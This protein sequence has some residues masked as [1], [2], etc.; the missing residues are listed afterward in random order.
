MNSCAKHQRHGNGSSPAA[1]GGTKT[2]SGTHRFDQTPHTWC[3]GRY[4]G[5][6]CPW[7]TWLPEDADDDLSSNQGR[8]SRCYRPLNWPNRCPSRG[9]ALC[10]CRAMKKESDRTAELSVWR[11]D[12]KQT[13]AVPGDVQ[14]LSRMRDLIKWWQRWDK[15]GRLF[16]CYEVSV[17]KNFGFTTETWPLVEG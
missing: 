11:S 6:P 5:W 8:S 7:F 10:L 2:R 16:V 9:H 17:H 12:M 13:Q 14:I 1:P 3:P 15:Y 4:T